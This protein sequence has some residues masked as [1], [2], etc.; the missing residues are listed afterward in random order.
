MK[1]KLL[2]C[3]LLLQVSISCLAQEWTHVKTIKLKNEITAQ[4]V[5]TDGKIYLGTM[6]GDMLRYDQD[7]NETELYSAV[8]NFP[9]TLISAWNRFKVFLYFKSPQQ[10]IFLDRFS[11]SP[12]TYS[13]ADYQ[14]PL[15]TLCAPG[16]DN[17]VWAL[18]AD[19]NELRKYNIQNS[20]VLLTNPLQINL[21]NASYMQAYQNLVLISDTQQGIHFFDQYG[22]LQFSHP[23]KGVSYFQVVNDQLV[24][25]AGAWITTIDVFRPGNITKI[26]A[27]PGG[28][29][30]VLKWG[31]RYYFIG[32]DQVLI[33]QLTL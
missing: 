14:R 27:P 3:T 8:G 22:N 32:K 19:Y 5:D 16:I 15:V 23:E 18:S 9:V 4:S 31:D 12:I 17:S 20:N 30:N 25:L 10:F 2:I 11:T 13:L 7:G 28:F 33:Y 1:T 29:N 21:S 6:A 24:F 26:K